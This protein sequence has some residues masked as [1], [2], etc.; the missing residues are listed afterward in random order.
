M[1]LK[2]LSI[3]KGQTFGKERFLADVLDGLS[4]SFKKLQ[5]K[6]FY[7]EKGDA[8]FCEIMGSQDY[9]PTDSEMEI[10]V[11]Q[12]TDILRAITI[13][14][15]KVD[16]IELGAGD[17]SKSV[18]LL[19]L[20]AWEGVDYRYFP[21][22]ISGHIITFLEDELPK[23]IPGI[24]VSGLEGEYLEMLE[25]L[26]ASV[27]PKL[28]LFLGS[29][30]GNM[31]I[32]EAEDFCLKLRNSLRPGDYLFM[33]V[34]LK[35]DPHIILAAYNDR[36]GITA[37]FNLNLLERINSELDG[38][39]DLS[40]FK[41]F[42]AYDPRTGACRSYLVS[43]TDQQVTISGHSISFETG[44]VIEMEISQKF[45]LGEIDA[46]ASKAGFLLKDNFFDKKKWFVNTL[47]QAV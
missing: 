1:E 10:F 17:A 5:S 6:Y 14:H 33:G 25:T 24:K 13:L 44:E 8:L 34:D 27:N 11:H 22:D 43:T 30:V 39:F 28:L 35:K 20:L 7:D 41:H 4:S 2:P 16:V 9:Y 32:H 26:T 23:K 45:S 37:K 19:D 40:K 29:N 15:H 42:P 21:I 46:M 47:W 18:Y 12:A 31:E 38:N 36:E 3:D